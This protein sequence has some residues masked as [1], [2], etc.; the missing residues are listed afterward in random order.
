[1]SKPF[2]EQDRQKYNQVETKQK[3]LIKLAIFSSTVYEVPEITM[4]LGLRLHV[5]LSSF[6]YHPQDG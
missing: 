1:M 3:H 6:L 4:L 2:Q 5:I